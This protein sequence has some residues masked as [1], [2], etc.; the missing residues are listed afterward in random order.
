M[1]EAIFL[2]HKQNISKCICYSLLPSQGY[3]RGSASQGLE[4]P[5]LY[6]TIS[7]VSFVFEKLKTKSW[8]KLATA[9]I[10]FLKLRRFYKQMVMAGEKSR[11]QRSITRMLFDLPVNPNIQLSI[12]QNLWEN[13]DCL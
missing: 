13:F 10:H 3:P 1:F 12:H 9:T 2:R 4:G 8:L 5:K 11:P 6:E 7:Y